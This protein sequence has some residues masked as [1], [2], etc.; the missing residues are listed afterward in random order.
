MIYI[1]NAFS[2]QMLANAE[3]SDNVICNLRVRDR[4]VF[5]VVKLLVDAPE[6]TVESCI[7]HPDTAAVVSDIL[8][9]PIACNR[10]SITLHKGDY[11]IVAQLMGGRLPEGATK[12]PEGFAIKFMSVEVE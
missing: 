6:G 7:G 1:G 10:T 4:T 9:L 5:D 3:G 2:L 11:M 12:L 8:K